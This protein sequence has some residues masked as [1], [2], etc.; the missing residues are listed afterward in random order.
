MSQP[1]KGRRHSAAAVVPFYPLYERC[2]SDYAMEA[3]EFMSVD[4]IG[5][6]RIVRELGAGGMGK[7]FE[8]IHETIARRVA[9]KVLLADFAKHPEVTARFFN[10]A[11]AANLIDHPSIVQVSDFGHLSDGTAY[12]VMELLKGESLSSRLKRHGGCLPVSQALSLAWQIAEALAA[13]HACGIVHRDIK[14]S[15]IM[16]VP[17]PVAPG[18]ER[19][20]LLDFG[21]AK[22][23]GE[24]PTER[25]RT[26][27][28]AMLGTP[29]YMSPEQCRGAGTVDDKSDVYS[30]GVM[31]Y[32]MLAGRPPFIAEGQGEL[33]GQHLYEEPPALQSLAPAVPA[34]VCA[35]VHRMLLKDR[36]ARP[37]MNEVTQEIK[38]LQ[39]GGSAAESTFQRPLAVASTAVLR[40]VAH[41]AVTTFSSAAEELPLDARTRRLRLLG[42]V[43]VAVAF[44][45]AVGVLLSLRSPSRPASSPPTGEMNLRAATVTAQEVVPKSVAAAAT[46][47]SIRWQIVTEPT[48]ASVLG[49]DGKVLG[50]TPWHLTQAASNGT[51]VVRLSKPGY[52]RKTLTLNLDQDASRQEILTPLPRSVTSKQ[53]GMYLND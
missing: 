1:S 9:I 18:G 35:L 15:N 12:I 45:G 25:V 49:I 6:Y 50:T 47:R 46:Q 53:K 32:E 51:F 24:N 14:P 13:A 8:A 52:G 41:G 29:L 5:P 42:G 10:E 39:T 17:D 43:L 33:I 20:K 22:L 30:L 4:R 19:A 28:G 48:G 37:R 26:S 44:F 34:P 7:V 38:R 16:L 36:T 3:R 2:V 31:F 23:G 40:T 27:T 21:I 11:R